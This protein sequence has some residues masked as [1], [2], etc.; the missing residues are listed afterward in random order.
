MDVLRGGGRCT[1]LR[2]TK[3][4]SSPMGE[5]LLHLYRYGHASGR[6]HGAE[7]RRG[8]AGRALEVFERSAFIGQNALAVTRMRSWSGASRR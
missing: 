5:F 1:L 4:V 6:H 3:R 2:D 7:R 8:A